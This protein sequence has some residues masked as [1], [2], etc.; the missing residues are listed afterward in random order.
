MNVMTPQSKKTG[1]KTGGDTMEKQ[2]FWITAN[3]TNPHLQTFSG[4]SKGYKKKKIYPLNL[5]PR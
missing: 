1:D 3:Q 5:S 2:S 4:E